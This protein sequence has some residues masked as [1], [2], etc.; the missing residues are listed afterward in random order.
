MNILFLT[1]SRINDLSERGIYNDLMRKFRD[2]GHNVY[3]VSPSERRFKQK[4]GLRD[5]H[6]I[7]LLKIKTP[8]IQKTN[9]IEKGIGTLLI[10]YLFLLGVRKHLSG[11]KFDLV[12]Y[13]TPPITFTK[14]V[15]YIKTK[16][17]AISYLL[18][19]DIFPQNAVDLQMMKDGSFIHRYF[20]A[21]EEK[22]YRISDYIGCMS[23]ANVEYIKK[24]NPSISSDKIEVNPNCVE[25]LQDKSTIINKVNI[26]SQYNI[27]S[28]KTIF[29][30][31]GNLGKPQGLDFLL[32]VVRANEQN[33]NVFIV[34][35]GNGTEYSKIYNWF[36]INKPLN[37][38]LISRLP[39][40]EYDILV[41]SCDVGL[42]FLDKRFTIPNYPSR[43]LT[44]LEFKMPV[45]IATDPNTDIGIIAEENNYGY[46]VKSGDLEAIK[47]KI[48]LLTDKS[49]IKRMG[50]N[51]YNYL[52][53][54]YTVSKSY[55][56]IINHFK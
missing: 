14:I 35:A 41:N 47:N 16:H 50:E 49:K 27:P 51:G 36:E 6:G 46:W 39:K 55:S 54:N 40:N 34:I 23:P 22:M 11:I 45:L 33:S 48:Q 30:Y 43:L 7:K 20:R 42:I 17:G 56:I 3:V 1:V 37:A 29:I 28:D 4:T 31:G 15:Q 13:S 38:L 25:V 19:K 12:L 9:I 53:S 24:H 2:E 5:S 32:D 44:Y 26:L 8:N 21:K 10:E 52:V 18:L